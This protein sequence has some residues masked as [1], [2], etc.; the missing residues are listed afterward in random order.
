MKTT[1]LPLENSVIRSPLRAFFTSLMLA[2]FTLSPQAR[3]TCQEGCLTNYNT[4]LGEEALLNNTT[5]F[6]N[7]ASGA[8]TLVSNTTG[9]YN[10]A[11]GESALYSN[12]TGSSNGHRRACTD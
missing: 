4:S 3:A 11:I 9:N 2:C 10:T 7:T 1:T 12:T 8:F 5:G 6:D